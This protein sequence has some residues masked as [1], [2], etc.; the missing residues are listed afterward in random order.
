MQTA[1]I[2]A[3]LANLSLAQDAAQ[4]LS[5]IQNKTNPAA[6]QAPAT[7]LTTEP[8]QAYRQLPWHRSL[9]EARQQAQK[10]RKL[11]LWVHVVGELDGVV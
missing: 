2:A 4:L 1:V 11:V 7:A 3:L 10:E 8:G 5:E 9:T 6:A